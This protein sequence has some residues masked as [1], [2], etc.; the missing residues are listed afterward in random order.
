MDI[1]GFI[2]KAFID[3]LH[4]GQNIMPGYLLNLSDSLYVQPDILLN[5][6]NSVSGILP[7]LD[8]ALQAASSISSQIR[9]LFSSLQISTIS[10]KLYRVINKISSFPTILFFFSVIILA[11]GS[12][13]VKFSPGMLPTAWEKYIMQLF[14]YLCRIF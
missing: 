7:S 11:K 1:L 4:K 6:F 10:G 8:Q 2:T 13:I 9:Y 5:L 14:L 3:C 12:I